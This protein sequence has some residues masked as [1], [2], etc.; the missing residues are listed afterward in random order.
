MSAMATDACP[1]LNLVIVGQLLSCV[2][3]ADLMG[4]STSGL[5]PPVCPS[6]CP[7]SL[8]PLNLSYFDSKMK[9]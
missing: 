6:S 3:P 7:L 5:Y 2:H 1:S 4:C 8:N 9:L